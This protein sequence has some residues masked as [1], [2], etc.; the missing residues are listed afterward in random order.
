MGFD[1]QRVIETCLHRKCC[2][3]IAWVSSGPYLSLIHHTYWSPRS[4]R[5]VGRRGWRVAERPGAHARTHAAPSV[6]LGWLFVCHSSVCLH[7]SFNKT[8]CCLF[9]CRPQHQPAER[10]ID[11]SLAACMYVGGKVGGAAFWSEKI[12]CR[13]GRTKR[14]REENIYFCTRRKIL[15]YI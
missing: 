2:C 14:N 15:T 8:C 7:R 10:L 12:Y 5:A 3:L 9:T 11:F 6:P 13:C 4:E 1:W